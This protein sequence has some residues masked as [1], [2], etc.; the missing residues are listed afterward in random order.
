ME[1]PICGAGLRYSPPYVQ[2]I[3][4]G[5]FP[6]LCLVLVTRGIHEGLLVSLKMVALWFFGSMIISALISRIKP[7]TLKLSPP[8]TD[9]PI[10]LFD[11]RNK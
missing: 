8:K 7:P 2:I 3:L 1:C 9:T 11:K 10:Q 5:S 6:F 4:W